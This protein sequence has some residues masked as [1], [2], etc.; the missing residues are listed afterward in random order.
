MAKIEQRRTS[1]MLPQKDFDEADEHLETEVPFTA[2][3][4][5]N[6]NDRTAE[7]VDNE[8]DYDWLTPQSVTGSGSGQKK[9]RRGQVEVPRIPLRN[10]EVANS[11]SRV[12]LDDDDDVLVVVVR[13][14]H[15]DGN[16]FGVGK[17]FTLQIG[18][19][20]ILRKIVLYGEHVVDI[21]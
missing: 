8:E 21:L 5:M 10:I 12:K 7:Y 1:N 4:L 20:Y 6:T 19:L 13:V 3:G 15:D 17:S 18:S 2:R 16:T 11:G 9:R 14:G